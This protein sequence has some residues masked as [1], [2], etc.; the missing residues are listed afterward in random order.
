MVVENTENQ[1]SVAQSLVGLLTNDNGHSNQQSSAASQE[2]ATR[3]VYNLA[4]EPENRGALSKWGAIPLLAKQLQDGTP[5]SQQ[6]AAAALSQIALKSPQHRVQVTAQ[7]IIL[8]GSD[9]MDVRQRAFTALQDMAAEGGSDNRMTVKMAGG[10]DRFVSLLKDGSL[11]AQEYAL[12]LLW[13]SNDNASKKSIAMARSAQPIVTILVSDNLSDVAKEHAATVLSGMTADEL[14]SIDEDTRATNKQDIVQGGGIL[15]LVKLLGSGSLGA[16]RH[17]ALTLAQLC[18]SAEGAV[19][20]TQLTI[21][22]AGAIPALVPWLNDADLGPPAM[23]ARGLAELSTDNEATQKTIVESGAVGP[24]VT[25]MING[26]ADAQK[27]AAAAIAALAANVD[28][29]EEIASC[30]GIPPLVELLKRDNK[31]PH[32]HA[33]CAVWHLASSR[34]NQLAIAAEGC[35]PPLVANLSADSA[36]AKWAAAALQALSRDCTE[37]QLALARVGAIEPLAVLLGSETEASQLYAQGALLNM[38]MAQENRTAVV[39]PLV[40]LLEVRNAAAQMKAAESLSM[41]ASRSAENRV[42]VAQAGAI[43]ALVRLLGDGNNVSTSQ[44]RAAAALGD[45]ARAGECKQEIVAAGGVEPLVKMLLSPNIEAQTRATIA[46]CQLAA[47][48]TSQQLIADADGIPHL[49]GLLSS[50]NATAAAN[51]AGALWHL[52]SLASTKGV[53]VAVGGIPALVDLL[54]RSVESDSSEGLDAIAALL[55][56]LARERGSTKASIV[57]NGGI[58]PLV[59]LLEKGSA[60]A[61][62]HASCAIWGLTSE[63][64]Y[65]KAVI[66]ADAVPGLTKV[67]VGG[68]KAQGYAAAALNNL[69]RDAEAR[70]QM[71]EGGAVAPLNAICEGPETWL[72]S[73]AAGIL[74]QLKIEAPAARS[75][76]QEMAMRIAALAALKPSYVPDNDPSK[77]PRRRGWDSTY[78]NPAFMSE[79]P[80][81]NVRASG[82]LRRHLTAMP[83]PHLTLA[84]VRPFGAV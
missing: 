50:S 61:Q 62:K 20:D 19:V 79:D 5:S 55:S 6:D 36:R 13:Q 52:E 63:P 35:L 69:A 54:C 51:A 81:K 47:S 72:R 4:L 78:G 30:G 71:V 9:S 77:S 43:P 58:K 10:I 3:L 41:L 60:M 31:G 57:Q 12:W 26:S 16:K 64:P 33:T 46:V 38:A 14:V 37:N 65:Q 18:R 32:E 25:M 73:Q 53:I 34:D 2:H 21:V 15:P 22:E 8:L 84:S 27:W 49:V 45:L 42:V 48:N 70:Q 83:C 75:L 1:S 80:E 23:A 24:L 74:Q 40:E 56:D 28:S 67:L 82:P 17:A 76:A 7:M 68:A 29:Q 66:R 11:E 59:K 39:K 44:I